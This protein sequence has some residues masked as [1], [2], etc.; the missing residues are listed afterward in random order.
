MLF[1]DMFV[2]GFQFK[3][4]S[5]NTVQQ[6]TCQRKSHQT[7]TSIPLIIPPQKHQFGPFVF[8]TPQNQGGKKQ[9]SQK[10]LLF[11]AFFNWKPVSLSCSFSSE[12]RFWPLLLTTLIRSCSGNCQSV[13]IFQTRSFKSRMELKGWT[14]NFSLQSKKNFF[15]ESESGKNHD[16]H[17]PEVRIG[18]RIDKRHFSRP[19]ISASK[20]H[21]SQKKSPWNL[22]FAHPKENVIFQPSFFEWAMMVIIT[23]HR[24]FRFLCGIQLLLDVQG[25]TCQ[26]VHLSFQ[27][28][29]HS[30]LCY[31]Y[32]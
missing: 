29:C 27:V 4:R 30:H 31:P 32:I 11:L 25:F 10:D 8:S 14:S 2:V 23:F 5:L 18:Q 21:Q 1:G 19:L 3:H 17:H 28:P 22:Q 15:K 7:I 26:S 12:L 24:A 6:K 9:N 16:V 20:V 13:W